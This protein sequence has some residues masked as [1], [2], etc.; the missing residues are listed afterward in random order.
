M[1]LLKDKSNAES[2]V[3]SALPFLQKL[4]KGGIYAIFARLGR[5]YLSKDMQ[6]CVI[7]AAIGRK[8]TLHQEPFP[9]LGI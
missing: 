3:W 1:A 6:K 8:V 9:A 4:G 7:S 2:S 5:E